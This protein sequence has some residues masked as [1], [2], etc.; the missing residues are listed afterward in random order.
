MFS[1]RYHAP[2]R[3]AIVHVA[4]EAGEREAVELELRAR[5][6]VEDEFIPMRRRL[7][8]RWAIGEDGDVIKFFVD[9]S[10]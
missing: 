3:I 2:A 9:R 4:F 10:W 8:G 7:V 1:T 5:A 6:A